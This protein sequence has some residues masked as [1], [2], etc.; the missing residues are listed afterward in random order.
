MKAR[1]NIGVSNLPLYSLV[2]VYLMTFLS[3]VK[4]KLVRDFPG[5]YMLLSATD[6]TRLLSVHLQLESCRYVLE[7]P[8]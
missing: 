2:V 1:W 5:M 4:A 7:N 3:Q 6:I 8:L